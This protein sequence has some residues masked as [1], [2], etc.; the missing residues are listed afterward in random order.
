MILG[1]PKADRWLN[2][3]EASEYSNLSPAT[4]RRNIKSNKLKAS[5][6]LGKTLL[7]TSE[8]EAFLNG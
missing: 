4:L 1:K 8:I 3:K 2:I 5:N 7:K 6:R